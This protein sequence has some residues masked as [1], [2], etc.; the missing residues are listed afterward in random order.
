MDKTLKIVIPMAGFGKRLRPQTWSRPKQLISVADKTALDHLIETFKT[1]PDSY[2]V[3]YVF[4]VGYLGEQIEAHMEKFHPQL[5]VNYVVQGEMRGQSHAI[6]LTEEYLSGPM[7]MVFAD[8]LL[9]TD[10]AFLEN[11]SADA[12]AWVKAVPDPRRFGVAAVNDAGWVTKLIEKPQDLDNNLAV[13]GFYY[14]K[15]SEDLLG[16]ID[17]QMRLE[18]QLKGEFYLAEAVNI[19]LE[20]GLMMRIQNV[21][22]WLDTGTPDYVLSTNRY[23]LEHGYDNNQEAAIRQRVVVIPPVFIHPSAEVQDCV[24]GPHTSIGAECQVRGSNIQDSILEQG[25]Q[26]TEAVLMGSIIGCRAQV[27]G[28]AMSVNIGDDSVLTL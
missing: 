5:D 2:E 4:I 12:V 10:L 15:S 11:E 9:E 27:G 18:R 16:A 19:M 21:E 6:S 25:A 13:V 23:L 17:E 3:S 8:T 22:V 24:I 1:I 7:L 26:V 28:R 14:F 20:R